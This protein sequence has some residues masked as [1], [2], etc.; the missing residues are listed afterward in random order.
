MTSRLALADTARHLVIPD[1]IVSTGWPAV[2]DTLA[3]LGVVFDG[4]QVDTSRVLLGKRADG[5]YACGEGGAVLSIGRQIGKTFLVGSTAFALALLTPNLTV[6]WTAHRLRTGNET[7]AKMQ[8]FAGQRKVKP[9]IQQI[10]V[11]SGTGEIVFTNG[12]R[13]LFGARERGFGRGFD[14]VDMI[15]FDEAQILTENAI[16]DM[17][18]AANTAANPLFLFVGTPPKPSDPSAVFTGKRDAALAAVP[19]PDTL[20]VEMSADDDA[21]LDDPD[22]WAKANPSFPVRTPASAMRRMRKNL[23]VE[24][25]RREAL[26]IWGELKLDADPRSINLT[27][28]DG[29][30]LASHRA[31]YD[32]RSARLAVAVADD[33]SWSSVAVAG[34]TPAG[35]EVVRIVTNRPGTDWVV[36]R[37]PELVAELGNNAPVAVMKGDPLAGLLVAAGVEIKG[38]GPAD[39]STATQ[40]II[41]ATKVGSPVIRHC[42]EPEVRKSLGLA[43]LRPYGASRVVW[44]TGPLGGDISPLL[45]V[46]AAYGMLGSDIVDSVAE[47]SVV[48]A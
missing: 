14:D 11:G 47:L 4:W 32:H 36:S 23:S 48:F 34:V 25:F 2:R 43:V 38:V 26:G 10:Y 33:R 12:S 35:F 37:V 6:L 13:I 8:A 28:W 45:A 3:T 16:D 39:M 46:T 17:L 24:S 30:A 20:F 31:E 27:V 5:L 19:D 7:F 9:F 40:K 18:P 44:G 42:G 21:D 1:G 22:Q 15:V 29:L 41:D